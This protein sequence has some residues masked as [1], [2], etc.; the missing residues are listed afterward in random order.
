MDSG[1]V[2]SVRATRAVD[3]VVF[4]LGGV[5]VDWNPRHLYRRLFGAD[6]DAMEAF[7]AQ[8]CPVE[9]NEQQ[10]RG[11]PWAEAI[12]EAISR[13]PDQVE[14]IHA[15]RER[16]G[17]MLAGAL[18]DSVAVLRELRA[19][20]TRLLAL[21]NWSAETFPIA[22]QRF[23]FLQWFEGIVVSGRE[24]MMKPEAAIFRCLVERYRLVPERTV[25][26]DDHPRNVDAAHAFG[27]QALR[28]TDA[29]RLRGDLIALGLPLA[30]G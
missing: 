26:I 10:D 24:G 28:F 11:R 18:G 3:A 4:D 12:E 2:G 29:A 19:A 21:T 23:D 30:A 16:W 5:L 20:G 25:F 27:L 13:H 7:L 17:E 1:A 9:W 15:Y 22:E 8:V 14:Y 6:E